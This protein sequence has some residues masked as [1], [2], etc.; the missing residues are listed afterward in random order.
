MTV[1]Q[2]VNERWSLAF[3]SDAHADGRRFR[4]LCVLD[5]FS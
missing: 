5:D 4:V 1:P 2:A 3:A